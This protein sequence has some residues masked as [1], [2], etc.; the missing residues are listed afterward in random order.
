[1][2]P[3]VIVIVVYGLQDMPLPCVR[4]R[5][6]LYR[7]VIM[8]TSVNSNQCQCSFRIGCSERIRLLFIP[9]SKYNDSNPILYDKWVFPVTNEIRSLKT[10][11]SYPLSIIHIL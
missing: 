2:T 3:I 10:L 4:L 6:Y 8:Y 9:F 5:S 11:V 7:Y 1:M